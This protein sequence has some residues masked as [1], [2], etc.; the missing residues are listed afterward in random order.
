MHRRNYLAAIN[1]PVNLDSSFPAAVK[2]LI[3][4]A[5]REAGCLDFVLVEIR[6]NRKGF[7]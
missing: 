5:V 6:N 2:V 3:Q 1:C 7:E 4:P